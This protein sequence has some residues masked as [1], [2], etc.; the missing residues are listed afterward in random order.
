MTIYVTL[1][2]VRES[3]PVAFWCRV[4]GVVWREIFGPGARIRALCHERFK[5]VISWVSLLMS[6]TFHGCYFVGC[7]FW[8]IKQHFGL[9]P[10]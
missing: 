7:A 9:S 2:A 10:D 1:A 8:V 6:V 4:M 5:S 3:C